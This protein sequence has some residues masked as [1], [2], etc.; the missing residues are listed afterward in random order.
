V[1]SPARARRLAPERL[2]NQKRSLC[3]WRDINRMRHIEIPNPLKSLNGLF[4]GI[5]NLGFHCSLTSASSVEPGF[6][7][8]DF[9]E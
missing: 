5:W 1:P 9:P 2:K 6:G 4:I 7:H 8:W 3:P